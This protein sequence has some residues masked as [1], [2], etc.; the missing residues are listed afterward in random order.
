[1]GKLAALNVSYENGVDYDGLQDKREQARRRV[2][3]K[4][5]NR[6]LERKKKMSET[7]IE[8]SKDMSRKITDCLEFTEE[9]NSLMEII[10]DRSKITTKNCEA[11]EA[12]KLWNELPMGLKLPK[13]I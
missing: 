12:L 13:W 3:E 6:S 9:L 1:M 11:V 10:S 5:E 4:I 2:R 8:G 7:L